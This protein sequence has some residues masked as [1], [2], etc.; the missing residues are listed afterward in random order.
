MKDVWKV[1]AVVAC[2]AVL[3]NT[4]ASRDVITS[5]PAQGMLKEFIGFLTGEEGQTIVTELEFISI[6]NEL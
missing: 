6:N 2:L 3:G 1:L 5:G 4:M